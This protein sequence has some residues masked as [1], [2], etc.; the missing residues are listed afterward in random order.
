MIREIDPK[1]ERSAGKRR[2]LG[3][4]MRQALINVGDMEGFAIVLWDGRGDVVTNYYTAT[5]PVSRAMMPGYVKD[6]LQRHVACEI[7][8][9]A[10]PVSISD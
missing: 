5:G 3:K 4:C 7:M 6:A 10:N 9:A 2:I 1:G 8:Q